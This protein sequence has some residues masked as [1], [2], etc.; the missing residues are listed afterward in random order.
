MLRG[1]F[2]P[3]ECLIGI[4]DEVHGSDHVE[5]LVLRLNRGSESQLG[6]I[7]VAVT[8]YVVEGLMEGFGLNGLYDSD[9]TVDMVLEVS[10]KKAGAVPG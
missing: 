6:V 3:G 2:K 1:G 10:A 8:E 9:V 7:F 5:S 4:A